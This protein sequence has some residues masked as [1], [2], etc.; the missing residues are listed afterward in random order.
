MR[1]IF[2][3]PCSMLAFVRSLF[4]KPWYTSS[5][6]T[7]PDEPKPKIIILP[8]GRHVLT[9]NKLIALT[10][11]DHKIPECSSSLTLKGSG[12]QRVGTRSDPLSAEP[13]T[14]SPNHEQ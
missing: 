2:R 7:L 13:F 5:K 3:L 14:A 6:E 1:S 4:F 9:P 10:C 8:K 11:Q 12:S